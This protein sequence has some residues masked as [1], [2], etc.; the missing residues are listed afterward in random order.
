MI[1]KQLGC[2]DPRDR[3]DR[4]VRCFVLEAAMD[5]DT[6]VDAPNGS[7][8][9]LDSSK[10]VP[11]G[12]L[13]IVDFEG[14]IFTNLVSSS[15]DY[16]HERSKEEGGVLVAGRGRLSSLVRSFDPVPTTVTMTT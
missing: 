12:G 9:S 6:G 1:G 15:T 3:V 16:H 5:V 13:G 2:V 8:E 11:F 7:T 10:L 14:N 4:N